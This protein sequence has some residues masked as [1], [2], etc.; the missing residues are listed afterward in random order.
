MTYNDR[1]GYDYE[2]VQLLVTERDRLRAELALKDMD[3]RDMDAYDD[4]WFALHTELD[5]ARDAIT[6]VRELCDETDG[7]ST[8]RKDVILAAIEGNQL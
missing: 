3:T 7:P 1:G 5:E 4:R 6:R 2:F 8:V